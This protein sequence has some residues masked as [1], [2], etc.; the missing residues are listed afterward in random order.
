[1]RIIKPHGRVVKRQYVEWPWHMFG[2]QCVLALNVTLR[3]GIRGTWDA[4]SAKHLTLDFGSG[5]GLINLTLN[6]TLNS[7]LSG[8]SA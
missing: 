3:N 2:I 1:M 7:V 6:S 5:H 8:E 4:Q